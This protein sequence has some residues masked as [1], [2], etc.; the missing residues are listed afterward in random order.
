MTGSRRNAARALL[1]SSAS[2]SVGKGRFARTTWLSTAGVEASKGFDAHLCDAHAIE[3]NFFSRALGEVEHAPMR[4][5]SAIGD[6]DHHGLTIREVGDAGNGAE[7]KCLV[8]QRSCR[9]HRRP[10][11]PRRDARWVHTSWPMPGLDKLGTAF[12][13]GDGSAIAASSRRVGSV[14]LRIACAPAAGRGGNDYMFMLLALCMMTAGGGAPRRRR[15]R[16]RTRANVAQASGVVR[17]GRRCEVTSGCASVGSSCGATRDSF[18][19]LGKPF[20]PQCSQEGS[21]R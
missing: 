10:S 14:G 8:V 6:A 2:C 4:E 13:D 16:R 7:R 18:A 20:P 3:V 11:R 21:F 17:C 12:G 9:C 1:R 15:R 5:G 19:M